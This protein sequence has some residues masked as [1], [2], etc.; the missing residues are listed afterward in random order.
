[1]D[2]NIPSQNSNNWRSFPN[3]FIYAGIWDEKSAVVRGN[4][5]FYWS[6]TAAHNGAAQSFYLDQSHIQVN[7]DRGKY[8]GCSVR[9]VILAQ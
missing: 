7:D 5:G 3:N 4:Y 2:S 9:C 6:R 8:R 1:M